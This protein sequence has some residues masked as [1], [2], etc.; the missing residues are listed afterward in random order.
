MIMVET[1]IFSP[2]LRIDNKVSLDSGFIA[3]VSE[4][5]FTLVFVHGQMETIKHSYRWFQNGC[6][7]HFSP[8]LFSNQLLWCHSMNTV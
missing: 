2:K 5:T 1:I 7:A 4:M 6:F 8:A 3:S